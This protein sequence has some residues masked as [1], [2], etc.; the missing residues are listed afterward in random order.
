MCRLIQRRLKSSCSIIEISP[1]VIA[2][3]KRTLLFASGTR[4]ASGLR[5]DCGVRVSNA[6]MDD[7]QEGIGAFLD[8]RPPRWQGQ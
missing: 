4:P 6:P 2:L 5:R 3:G 1:A 7:A 8:K